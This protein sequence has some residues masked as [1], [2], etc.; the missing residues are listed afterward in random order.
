MVIRS[1][2]KLVWSMVE[3]GVEGI[4]FTAHPHI[5][6][7]GGQLFRNN[8]TRRA[9]TGSVPGQDPHNFWQLDPDP[10]QS[11]KR[12]IRNRIRIKVYSR[13]RIR[14]NRKRWK[15]FSGSFWSTGGSK[16]GKKWMVGSA[17]KWKVGS[18]A[19]SKWKAGSGSASRWSGSANWF[20]QIRIRIRT[21]SITTQC[22]AYQYFFSEN[23]NLPPKLLKTGTAVNK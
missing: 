20:R 14:I 15:P 7:K 10:H 11:V 19:A 18:G 16:S 17:S 23:F 4:P 13:I 8:P 1:N 22:K 3:E 12:W 21:V 2:L 6:I 9:D 5:V